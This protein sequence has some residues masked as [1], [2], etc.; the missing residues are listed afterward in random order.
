MPSS[1]LCEAE[2]QLNFIV[3]WNR[4]TGGWESAHLSASQAA[5]IVDE[6]AELRKRVSDSWSIVEDVACGTTLECVTCKK[7]MPCNCDKI[8]Q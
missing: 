5:A 2:S 7:P 3:N 1:P 6:L 4:R 8:K